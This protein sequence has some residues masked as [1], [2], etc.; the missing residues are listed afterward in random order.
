VSDGRLHP[1]VPAGR[2]L[3]EAADV[4]AGLID[5]TVTGKVVLVP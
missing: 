2:P 4:M 1:T 3:A 5:R